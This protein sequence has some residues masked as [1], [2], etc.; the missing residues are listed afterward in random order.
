MKPT[1]VTYYSR[2]GKTRMVAKKLAE[3]LDAD[4]E[5]IEDA[6]DRRGIRGWISGGKDALFQNETE[7]RN[8][9]EISERQLV[10][11]GTPVWCGSP[12]P[13]VRAFIESTDFSNVRIAIFCT[14]DGGGGKGCFRKL[15]DLLPSQPID[16]LELKKPK[17]N[18]PELDEKLNAWAEEIRMQM[19]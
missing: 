12:A 6:K 7:L 1:L 5:R 8:T 15:D 10:V 13:A 3:L 18:D 17:S 19:V 9:P 2:T 11:I 16:L 4:L 14:H